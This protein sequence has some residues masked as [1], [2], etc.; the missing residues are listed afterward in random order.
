M[1]EAK[2]RRIVGSTEPD[3]NWRR[4]L[5]SEEIREAV[6]SGMTRGIKDVQYMWGQ[7]NKRV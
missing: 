6:V 1:G 5:S 7:M 4:K 2:R 3:P